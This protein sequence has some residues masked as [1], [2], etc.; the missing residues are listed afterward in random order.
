MPPIIR[1]LPA[2]RPTTGSGGA[3]LLDAQADGV[4]PTPPKDPQSVP[5]EIDDTTDKSTAAIRLTQL[6]KCHACHT[7]FLTE[8]GLTAH[9]QKYPQHAQTDHSDIKPD[10]V[11]PG[12][13]TRPAK[14]TV[15]LM[16]AAHPDGPC[17]E[18]TKMYRCPLCLEYDGRKALISHLRKYHDVQR[19][20]GFLFDPLKDMHMGRLA[21]KHCYAQFTMEIALRTHFQRA[22]C[23][24]LLCNWTSHQHFGEPLL[25]SLDQDYAADHTEVDPVRLPW[26]LGLLNPQELHI[27]TPETASSLLCQPNHC[28]SR[29]LS[30]VPEAKLTWMVSSHRLQA[31]S[32]F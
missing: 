14:V 3:D 19:P 26:H 22:S 13:D 29:V 2:S 8:T 17:P 7:T 24:V 21:R 28:M 20:D 15:K 1:P 18:P 25:P 10:S 30:F 6:F 16:L 23:P 31:V 32:S 27:W 5:M 11:H 12:T 4:H 9:H